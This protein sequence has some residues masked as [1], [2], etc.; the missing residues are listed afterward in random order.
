MQA[1]EL[2]QAINN[3]TSKPDQDQIFQLVKLM[4]MKDS[5]QG[6]I[7]MGILYRKSIIWADLNITS[8]GK[9][10]EDIYAHQKVVEI[11]AKISD[12]KQNLHYLPGKLP[13]DPITVAT[14]GIYTSTGAGELET[15]L[16]MQAMILNVIEMEHL[17]KKSF[18]FSQ[19][20]REQF[21]QNNPVQ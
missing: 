4:S 5:L 14:P 15:S 12:F 20:K 10:G 11:F 19:E 13:Y 9:E 16:A 6:Q 21:L 2:K 7:F 8:G 1:S 3:F 17:I 18:L